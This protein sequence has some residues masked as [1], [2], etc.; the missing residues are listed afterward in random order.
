MSRP[1]EPSVRSRAASCCSYGCSAAIVALQLADGR[2]CKSVPRRSDLTTF[3]KLAHSVEPKTATAVDPK[4]AADRRMVWFANGESGPA[5][6][7]NA[8]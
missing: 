2:T 1:A 4:A 3:V 8:G 6:E 7:M 5:R